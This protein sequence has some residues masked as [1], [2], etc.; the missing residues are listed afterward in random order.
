[1]VIQNAATV[2]IS[3]GLRFAAQV[4]ISGCV[5][6]NMAPC[7]LQPAPRSPTHPLLALGRHRD[8][9]YLRLLVAAIARY[10]ICRARRRNRCRRLR[11]LR[12]VV[13]AVVELCTIK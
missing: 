5:A 11:R 4:S 1:M 9:H 7:L 3:M 8:D 12:Q 13:H 6:Q 2:N 10:A